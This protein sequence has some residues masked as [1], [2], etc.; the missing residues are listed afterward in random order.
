MTSDTGGAKAPGRPVSF[1]EMLTACG[2]ECGAIIAARDWSASPLGPLEDWPAVL[3]ISL[4]SM[5]AA[6]VPMVLLW[7]QDGILLYNDGYAAFSAA[8]HPAILGAKALESWPEA[9]DFNANVL[10]TVLAGGNLAYKDQEMVLHHHGRPETVWLNLDYFPVRDLDGTPVGVGAILTDTTARVLAE[11]ATNELN[12]TLERRVV[13]AVA[14]RK[15]L[16]DVVEATDA[17][18]QAADLDFNW[19]AINEA[20]AGEFERIFGVRPKVGDNMLAILADQPEHQAAVRAVWQ[21][22]IDGEAF[23]SVDEFGDPGRDRRAYEMTFQPLVDPKGQRIGAFQFVYDVTDDLEHDAL[24]ATTLDQLRERDRLWSLSRDCFLIADSSGQWLEVSAAWTD[25]L[26]WSEDELTGKTSE[27]L[28]H[29]DD[30]SKTRDEVDYLAEGGTTFRFENRLRDRDGDYHTFSW[31][32]TQEDGLLFCVARDIS[33]ERE[34]EQDL[35][36]TRDFARLALGAVGGVGVWTFDVLTDRFFFDEGIARLYAL[37]PESGPGGLLRADF[38]AHVHPDDKANLR[39][40]MSGGLVNSG[41][42]ELEYRIVHPDGSVRWVLSRGNTYFDEAGKPTRRTGVGVDITDKRRL[43]EQLRQAQKMEAVGQLTGGIAHD[44]NNMLA[45][46]MGSLELLTR[47]LS[48]EDVR[49]RHY[50]QQALEGAKRAANLT[51]RLLAFSRQQPLRPEAVN[52]HALVSGMSEL[53]LHSLGGAIQLET[54]LAPRAWRVHADPNQ[55]ENVLL[56]LGVNARD[57]MPNGGRLTLEI[58]NVHLDARYLADDLGGAPGQYV[59]IAVSDTGTGMPPEVVAKAFDPFFTTKEVGKGTGLG[60][61]QVYGF[62]KQSNGHIRIYSE[63][64]QGTTIKI[65]LPRLMS[66]EG[67]D[68]DAGDAVVLLPGDAQ[69]VVLVVD[70]EAVVRQFSKDALTELGYRVLEADTAVAALRLVEAHPE[71]RLLFTDVVMPEVNGR[72]LA[73]QVRDKRPDIRVLFTTGYTRNAVVHNGTLDPG[74]DL[75][76]KPFTIDEL[77]AKVREVLDRSDV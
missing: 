5:L 76:G 24:L 16:A 36:D 66:E 30:R 28:E 33:E 67:T 71:I 43:E 31:T 75:I 29:P 74:V 72:Q 53:L 12:E 32:A 44:F 4:T 15:I 48:G 17:F 39:S 11:R 55:L 35:N 70:D 7:G 51:Q 59:L 23:T 45:V 64:G 52:V 37:D 68:S 20:A 10:K 26:G 1:A 77:A 18:I 58:Q 42:L 9:A 22:A 50:T 2:G 34:R 21:K 13:A 65:Y 25:I 27:W 47:R 6:P 54:V 41:D 69:E 62:V 56:N 73:D 57:A 14:E 61:S 49:A 19:M 8:R 3:R 38:L 63:V 40:T 46:I 60:L